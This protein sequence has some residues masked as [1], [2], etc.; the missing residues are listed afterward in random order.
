MQIARSR[1]TE[2]PKGIQPAQE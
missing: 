1:R 2:L